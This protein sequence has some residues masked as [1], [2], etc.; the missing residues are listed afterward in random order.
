MEKTAFAES[1]PDGLA[2]DELA[3]DELAQGELAQG[4]LAQGNAQV[5]DPLGDKARELFGLPYLFP[6]QRLVISNIMEAAQR[7]RSSGDPD[8]DRAAMGSQIVILP[9]GAGKSLCFQL[10]AMLLSGPTLVL[11]P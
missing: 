5:G 1:V 4:E 3:Q 8:G 7:E 9:T 2:Q 10:P 6:Y 11:Y